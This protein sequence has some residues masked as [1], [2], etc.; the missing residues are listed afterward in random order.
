MVIERRVVEEN[1]ML[2][3]TGQQN[4]LSM[5]HLGIKRNERESKKVQ[6]EK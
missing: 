4:F 6:L 2:K 5:Q 1:E 3:S